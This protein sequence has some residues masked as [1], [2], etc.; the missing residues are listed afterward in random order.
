[1][2][3]AWTNEEFLQ[4]LSKVTSTIQ[5]LEPYVKSSIKIKVKCLV[6]GNVWAVRPNALMVGKRC[7][8]CVAK[9]NG[10]R[11]RSTDAEF[12]EKLV[13]KYPFIICLGCY[14]T[15]HEKIDFR[16]GHCGFKWKQTPSEVLTYGC[17]NCGR[18]KHRLSV[19]EVSNRIQKRFPY[20]DIIGDYV[21]LAHKVLFRCNKC[22]KTWEIEPKKV[23]A[24]KKLGCPYCDTHV[25]SAPHRTNEEF[26][27][28]LAK[29]NTKVQPLEPYHRGWDPI[30]VRCKKCGRIYK[31]APSNLL[32]GYGCKRCA[33]RESHPE[34]LIPKE[35]AVERLHETHPYI[36]LIGKYRGLEKES[37]FECVRCGYVFTNTIQYLMKVAKDCPYCSEICY[38]RQESVLKRYFD[39]NHIGYQ[40]S[41]KPLYNPLTNQKLHFDFYLPDFGLLIE[42]QGY[43]HFK[44]RNL[45]GGQLGLEYLQWKDNYK[46]QWA[47]RHGYFL[48][49]I[50]F[51]EHTVE[52]F[53]SRLEKIRADYCNGVVSSVIGERFYKNGK[54]LKGE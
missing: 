2:V 10:F 7:P 9:R 26:L 37:Q 52:T 34:F 32:R 33:D 51:N 42:I 5:P 17:P 47:I 1:M 48:M 13:K 18:Q 6:C 46:K 19:E 11:L 45:F 39:E 54:L 25:Y 24:R 21:D 53:L 28:E 27:C 16:C 20:L 29:I 22:G 4:R 12:K 35:E 3:K 23:L 40:F 43:Q 49:Y 15:C 8:K 14:S 36:K 31:V 41:Y 44:P 30:K 38:S 50:N